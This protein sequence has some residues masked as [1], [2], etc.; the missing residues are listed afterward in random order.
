MVIAVLV[1]CMILGATSYLVAT[2]EVL[3]ICLHN[4]LPRG[5]HTLVDSH[6]AIKLRA[7]L[8]FILDNISLVWERSLPSRT[9][10][11]RHALSQELRCNQFALELAHKFGEI[12]RQIHS[13]L[14]RGSASSRLEEL[15]DCIAELFE[16]M[17]DAAM[18]HGASVP[19]LATS[20]YRLCSGS[21]DVLRHWHALLDEHIHYLAAL[22]T[23]ERPLQLL[24]ALDNVVVI[25]L[26]YN[27]RINDISA[28]R[29]EQA[30][31]ELVRIIDR[32]MVYGGFAE[33]AL[34]LHQLGESLDG[35]TRNEKLYLQASLLRDRYRTR[36]RSAADSKLP[37]IIA[38]MVR[39]I[40]PVLAYEVAACPVDQLAPLYGVVHRFES[41]LIHDIYHDPQIAADIA[42]ISTQI[43]RKI[44]RY[45]SEL[46]V[47]GYQNTL[48]APR[49]VHL[50][51]ISPGKLEL[52][53][54]KLVGFSLP[55]LNFSL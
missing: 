27:E 44:N 10:R 13:L 4:S 46:I 32:F 1:G 19:R 16:M 53:P 14:D 5:E 43:V 25:L 12:D 29:S 33:I 6:T 7:D 37:V 23:Y 28:A 18:G 48:L 55:R 22:R 34:V 42:H 35:A 31:S 40:V 50:I 2:D 11:F 21:C 39:D 47:V 24:V 52:C 51:E 45:I 20:A 54:I 15:E 36:V 8:G 17:E 49:V 41:L 3:P 26:E 38:D 9:I 30:M